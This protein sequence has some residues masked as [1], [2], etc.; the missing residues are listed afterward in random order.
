MPRG[1]W[2]ADLADLVKHVD[3][4]GVFAG[5]VVR[6]VDALRAPVLSSVRAY[7]YAAPLGRSRWVGSPPRPRELPRSVKAPIKI[8]SAPSATPLPNESAWLAK[9]L[10][11]TAVCAKRPALRS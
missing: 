10:L 4:A 3:G 1:R 2:A 5:V 8:E 7:R 6:A 11:S 9:G